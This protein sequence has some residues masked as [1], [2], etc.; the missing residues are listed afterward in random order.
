MSIAALQPLVKSTKMAES[1]FLYGLDRTPDD[2]LGWSPGG[3]A[4]TP[5]DV[6]G[7]LAGFLGFFNHLLQNHTMPERPAGPLPSPGS[8][9]EAKAAIEGAFERLRAILENMTETDLSRPLPTPWGT[10]IPALE[11]LGWINGVTGYWQG[12]LNYIQTIYGDV[13]PNT[14]PGWGQG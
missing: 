5:L 11:M 8:R 14:P 10:S 9:E 12:Q 4:K 6:A 7:R 13:D 1:R 3:E 2:R